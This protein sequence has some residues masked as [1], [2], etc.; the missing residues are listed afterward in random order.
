MTNEFA[1]LLDPLTD[2][3]SKA[4]HRAAGEHPNDAGRPRPRF[5][6]R[7]QSSPADAI[8]P[9]AYDLLTAVLHR[10]SA[11]LLPVVQFLPLGRRACTRRVA[12]AF[13]AAAAAAFGRTL[14]LD[15]SAAAGVGRRDDLGSA[16]ADADP[17]SLRRTMTPDIARP[18]LHYA[19]GN[20]H[21]A[22]DLSELIAKVAR[23]TA[24]QAS[25]FR[26]IVLD[27]TAPLARE[28]ALL[29]SMACTATI[30]VAIA[31]ES[32]LPRMRE[33]VRRLRAA[34]ASLAGLVL[35]HE[36]TTIRSALSDRV[37]PR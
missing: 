14:L 37:A 36:T 28:H 15:V 27:E 35:V 20:P 33:A 16:P 22:A 3:R 9:S 4:S 26:M 5:D 1:L 2:G 18:G 30:P 13:A 31:G 6:R 10:Q 7:R 34:G 8:I 12:A 11:D 32:Q 24:T 21:C 29:L 17:L 23:S 19:V 25:P